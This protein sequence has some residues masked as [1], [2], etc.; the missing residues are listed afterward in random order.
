[1]KVISYLNAELARAEQ[2]GA[3]F[4]DISVADLKEVLRAAE[5]GLSAERSARPMK[6]GGW[7]KPGGLRSV[8]SGHTLFT[9]VSR[10]RSDE[11]NTEIFF[12]DDL[13]V[14]NQEWL[15]AQAA[16]ADEAG[17]PVVPIEIIPVPNLLSRLEG[18]PINAQTLL[19]ID[20]EIELIRVNAA[21]RGY[22]VASIIDPDFPWLQWQRLGEYR[23]MVSARVEVTS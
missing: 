1:M 11:F 2:Q 5:S 9:R 19:A 3:R 22:K 18:M 21:A 8:R 7:I 4:L 17:P 6:H 16:S 13:K 15:D 14:K 12:A 20:R 10:R 23:S